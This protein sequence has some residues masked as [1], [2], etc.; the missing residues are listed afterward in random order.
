MKPEANFGVELSEM[1]AVS[2]LARFFIGWIPH[3]LPGLRGRVPFK[4]F[5]FFFVY[6]YIVADTPEEGIRSHYKWL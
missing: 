3:C 4:L 5:F 2:W 6:E 1:N